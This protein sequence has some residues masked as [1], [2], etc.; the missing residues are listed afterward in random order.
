[1]NTITITIRNL[2][3]VSLGNE[4]RIPKEFLNETVAD[5]YWCWTA[6]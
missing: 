4:I 5:I 3:K 6:S 1:M 2:T